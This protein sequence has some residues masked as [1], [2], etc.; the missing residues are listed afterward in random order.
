VVER[1]EAE[2]KKRDE[3][4]L[5]KASSGNMGDPPSKEEDEFF[6]AFDN[7]QTADEETHYAILGVSP[8]AGEQEIM[9]A[10][11]QKSRSCHPK[12]AVRYRT[13]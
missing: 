10:F 2:K 8:N 6:D 5:K 1:Q 9:S 11:R 4:R 7:L 13:V 3:A 12:T